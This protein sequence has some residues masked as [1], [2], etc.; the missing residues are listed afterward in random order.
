MFAVKSTGLLPSIFV[1]G[2]L[3]EWPRGL[4]IC[5]PTQRPLVRNSSL[6]SPILSI[7]ISSITITIG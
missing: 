4:G 7:R 1:V 6:S 5:C 2:L 3:V